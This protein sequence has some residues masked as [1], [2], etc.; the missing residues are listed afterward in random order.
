MFKRGFTLPNILAIILG[1]CV[2]AYF[3]MAGGES[4]KQTQQVEVSGQR[5]N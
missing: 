1:L 2:A 4:T 5:A 3:A